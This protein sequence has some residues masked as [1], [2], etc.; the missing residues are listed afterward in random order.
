M[1]CAVA[2]LW[3]DVP[4]DEHSQVDRGWMTPLESEKTW[5]ALLLPILLS[6]ISFNST[7]GS[8][9]NSIKLKWEAMES[10]WRAEVTNK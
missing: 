3:R 10:N 9:S 8:N 6:E 2:I 5:S 4:L 1:S 7:T